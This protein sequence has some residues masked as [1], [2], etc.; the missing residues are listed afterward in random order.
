MTRATVL[1]ADDHPMNT[2]LLRSLLVPAFDVV[3]DVA[4]GWELVAA[5]ERLS[6]DVIVTDIGM[7]GIDGIEAARRILARNP[8]ARVVFVTVQSDPEVVRRSLATGA[9]GYV[10]KLVAGDEL[11]PAVHA[12]LRG[13]RH[14]TAIAGADDQQ[15]W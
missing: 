6:P 4:D 3:G 5:A 9:M 7:P 8:S 13:E 2:V 1:L 15:R 12:A 11:V 10:V 14:V